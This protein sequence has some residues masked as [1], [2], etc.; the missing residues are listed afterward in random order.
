[1]LSLSSGVQA[2]VSDKSLLDSL[3]GT[4]VWELQPDGL[5]SHDSAAYKSLM[6]MYTNQTMQRPGGQHSGGGIYR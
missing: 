4:V 3:E 5:P 2:K 1:M 6:K